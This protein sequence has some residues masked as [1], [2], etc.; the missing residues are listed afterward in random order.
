MMDCPSMSEWIEYLAGVS[1]EARLAEHLESCLACRGRMETLRRL[2]EEAGGQLASIAPE[3]LPQCPPWEDLAA[4][5]ETGSA[6]AGLPGH[7]AGCESCL[8]QVTAYRAGIGLGT[9]KAPAPP[10]VRL[11]LPSLARRRG[12]PVSRKWYALSAGA[13]AL[14]GLLV[15]FSVRDAMRPGLPLY[16][17]RPSS[18]TGELAP[19]KKP[20]VTP[21]PSRSTEPASAPRPA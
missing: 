14:A 13:A 20:S 10:L 7:V 21:L 19:A 11:R 16:S 8:L 18:S 4:W 3:R 6:G 1:G 15:L 2:R 9:L 5:I 17:T 12:E